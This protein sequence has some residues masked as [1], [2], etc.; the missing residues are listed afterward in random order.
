MKFDIIVGGLQIKVPFEFRCMRSAVFIVPIKE[1]FSHVSSIDTLAL[2]STRLKQYEGRVSGETNG[3]SGII[4]ATVAD[5]GV[6]IIRAV[7]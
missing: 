5:F 1:F 3:I 6:C 2:M 7:W 4:T